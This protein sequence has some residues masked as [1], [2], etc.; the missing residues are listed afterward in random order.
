[1]KYVLTLIVLF[2]YSTGFAQDISVKGKV[3]DGS[4]EEEPLAFASVKVKGLDISVETDIDGFYQLNLLKGQYTL[5]VDFIG[6]DAVEIEDVVVTDINVNLSSVLL[7]ATRLDT[8]V[9]V[10]SKEE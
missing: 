10:A 9:L 7:E 8:D 6:Y 2:V 1:M 5:I 3:L 4:Y